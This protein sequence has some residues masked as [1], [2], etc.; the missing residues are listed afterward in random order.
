MQ[1]YY[2]Q[3]P[4]CSGLHISSHTRMHPQEQPPRCFL[5]MELNPNSCHR[6]IFF[7]A[8][9]SLW[10][11]WTIKSKCFMGVRWYCDSHFW[12]LPCCCRCL[13]ASLTFIWLLFEGG[14]HDQDTALEFCRAERNWIFVWEQW[15][16][17]GAKG[18]HS[19]TAKDLNLY[20]LT[21]LRRSKLQGIAY[22]VRGACRNL[23]KNL[24]GRVKYSR[25]AGNP[26]WYYD[27]EK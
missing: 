1:S 21:R 27:K 18:T 14:A 15:K 7:D 20:M 26:R 22:S 25:W 4:C 23:Q 3:T 6:Q 24:W 9:F 11:L 2:L 8:L 17:T 13:L 16:K 5:S 12:G 19:H 10:K